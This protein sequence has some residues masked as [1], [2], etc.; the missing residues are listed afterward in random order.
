MMTPSNRLRSAAAAALLVLGLSAC[1]SDETTS[2][3]T[4]VAPGAPSETRTTGPT[5]A[6]TDKVEVKDFTFKPKDTSVKAGTTVTWTF[7]DDS[8]HNV[9]PVGGAEPKKSPD[10]AAGKTFTHTFSKAG[11]FEYRCGI[12]NSMLGTV[13]VTA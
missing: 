6:T 3:A 1:G 11:T 8:D 2:P 4:T 5:G 12:H 7:S 9:E 10:L 13:V